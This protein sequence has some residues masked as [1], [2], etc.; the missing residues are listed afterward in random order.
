[1]VKTP[2]PCQPQGMKLDVTDSKNVEE[3][4][5]AGQKRDSD[6]NFVTVCCDDPTCWEDEILHLWLN[7][8]DIKMFYIN[9]DIAASPS[10]SPMPVVTTSWQAVT[11]KY[12]APDILVNNAGITKDCC[13]VI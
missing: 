5:K 13:E 10:S 8:F 7:L 4:V 2:A 11:E 9:Q 6:V 12:G 1:M 3:V